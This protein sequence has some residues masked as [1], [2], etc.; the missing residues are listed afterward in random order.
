M[1]HLKKIVVLLTSITICVFSCFAFVVY[2][3]SINTYSENTRDI[4]KDTQAFFTQKYQLLK[5]N[6]VLL[7]EKWKELFN[8]NIED[9]DFKSI[10]SQISESITT[11]LDEKNLIYSQIDIYNSFSKY[12][13]YGLDYDPDSNIIYLH[14]ARVH[15][16][17]DNY[18]STPESHKFSGML[19]EDPEGTINVIVERD[20]N[21]NIIDLKTYPQDTL[22]KVY[23]YLLQKSYTAN[24][25]LDN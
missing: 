20:S 8:T 1:K 6:D 16:F 24:S 22:P 5:E 7:N 21:K 23:S 18:S 13:E 19:C 4:T 3:N 14:N 9:P 11:I 25:A 10:Y 12:F 17:I 15:F 2:A